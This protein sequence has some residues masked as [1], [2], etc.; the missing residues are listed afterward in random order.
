MQ[1]DR[2]HQTSLKLS[3]SEK[4]EV[5]YQHYPKNERPDELA[6]EGFAILYGSGRPANSPGHAKTSTFKKAWPNVLKTLQQQLQ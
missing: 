5:T 6:A 1:A 3:A 4:K 2:K